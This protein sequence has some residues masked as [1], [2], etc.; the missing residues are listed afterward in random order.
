MIAFKITVTIRHDSGN[1]RQL[2]FDRL[3]ESTKEASTWVYDSLKDHNIV[4]LKVVPIK[5]GD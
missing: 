2:S 1:I 5:K 4:G 3:S